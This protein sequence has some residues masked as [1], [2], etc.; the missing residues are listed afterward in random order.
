MDISKVLKNKSVKNAGWIIGGRLTNKIIS[1][2]VS[3]LTA[4][5]LGPG[6]YGL[7]DYAA[8]YT[9]FF[10]SLCNLGIN[11]IIIKNFVDHPDEQGEA[12]GTAVVL[13]MLSSILS[14]IMICGIVQIVEKDE[15]VTILV[16]FLS[17]IGLFF[18]SFDTLKRWFQSRLQSKY[19]AIA[20]VI[21][22]IA[23]SVYKIALLAA[24]KSVEWFAVATSIDHI[25][26]ALCLMFA[27]RRNGGPRF[28]C[29][30]SKGK[31][32]LGASSGFI[33]S[34]LM[35][36]IYAA[37][38]KFMLKQMLDG[39][40]VAYYALSVTLSTICSFILEAIIDTAYPSIL[41]AYGNDAQRFA[42]RN[43][44]LY[45]MVF[46]G[47]ISVS[48]VMCVFSKP[49]VM[50]LYGK[51]YLPAVQPLRVIAWFTAFS[52]LGAARNAWVVC[53]NAQKYLKYLYAGA[54]L[55]NVV[56]NWLMIPVWGASGAAVA[57]LVTQIATAVVLPAM[58][59]ALRPNVKLMVEAVLL[60][61]V[62]PEKKSG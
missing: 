15:P 59:P 27:Y 35:I 17:S 1:F 40:A 5:Y 28:S 29:S 24:G 45:A 12:I 25:V 3:V 38:D 19:A 8:A 56:L 16:V 30:V 48:V 10:A 11:S 41:Q 46:Y 47:A 36:S 7:I 54:A 62:L 60:R 2:L 58:I 20:T 34:G 61:D 33:L 57:S 39:S 26:V 52:H 31:E 14:I 32:L 21:S 55:I 6:N 44:Q 37:T 49:I 50:L 22:Y 51:A 43:R 4:R 42:R 23:V 53:E 9:T 18:Q 13:R